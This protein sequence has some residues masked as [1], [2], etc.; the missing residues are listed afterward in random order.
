MSSPPVPVV[1]PPEPPP[2]QTLVCANCGAPLAGEYCG[3]CGQR[4]EPHVH[5]VTHFAAE[6]FESVT[7]ADSRLWRTLAYL[8]ARPGVLTREFFDGRRAGYL[9]PFRLYIVISVVFFLVGMPEKISVKP[10]SPGDTLASA[11]LIQQAEQFESQDS[12]LPEAMRKRSADYLRAEA[13]R[14][15]AREAAGIAPKARTDKAAA[16]DE[17]E[18]SEDGATHHNVNV[19]F[20]GLNEFCD[21]LKK[22]QS[23]N[24]PFRSNLLA[25]CRRLANGDGSSLGS[26]IVHNVPRAMFIFLPLLALVM[27]LLYWRP[28]RYYVE[29][30]L[31]LIHNHAFVFLA[32]TL[33]ILIARVPYTGPIM[34]WL[35][36]ITGGYIVWYLFR[37]MRNVY[38][39]GRGLTLAK[40][41][42]LGFTYL[43]TS[44]IMLILTVIYSA[45]TL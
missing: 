6:A 41:F 22:P 18:T 39:Q 31:F 4:H 12:P 29:H 23:A 14:A 19:S 26:V 40:Y 11:T 17:D 34:G 36:T 30:L 7:H 1:S 35:G 20:G 3:N 13:A 10:E 38:G 25:R 43:V 45:L 15:A 42:T 33:L 2:P 37:A 16:P 8:L 21:S 44:T 5:T 24:S 28:K 32:A 27:K 9:P